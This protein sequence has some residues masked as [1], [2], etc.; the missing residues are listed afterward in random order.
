M[1]DT[2]V[3]PSAGEDDAPVGEGSEMETNV[4]QGDPQT[5]VQGESGGATVSDVGGDSSV[6]GGKRPAETSGSVPPSAKKRKS[7]RAGVTLDPS[8]VNQP[9][10]TRRGK[11]YPIPGHAQPAAPPAQ[12]VPPAPPVQTVP[13]AQPA[14]PSA[15]TASPPSTP[16]SESATRGSSRG[17]GRGRG[18]PTMVPPSRTPQTPVESERV[19][20]TVPR[21][22][23]PEKRLDNDGDP[24]PCYWD[25]SIDGQRERYN[26][27]PEKLWRRFTGLYEYMSEQ[28]EGFVYDDDVLHSG[29]Q[30]LLDE[31]ARAL[32]WLQQTIAAE[33]KTRFRDQP[34]PVYGVWAK[35]L[36]TWATWSRECVHDYLRRASLEKREVEGVDYATDAAVLKWLTEDQ[37]EAVSKQFR[38]ECEQIALR[39]LQHWKQHDYVPRENRMERDADVVPEDITRS[40]HFWRR[41]IKG[42]TRRQ[43]LDPSDS[44]NQEEMDRDSCASSVVVSDGV[45]IKKNRFLGREGP[46]HRDAWDRFHLDLSASGPSRVLQATNRRVRRFVEECPRQSR[47]KVLKILTPLLSTRPDELAQMTVRDLQ[48]KLFEYYSS[49]AAWADRHEAVKQTRAARAQQDKEDHEREA[50]AAAAAERDRV[51]QEQRE[52]S[53]SSSRGRTTGRQRGRKSQ[54]KARKTTRSGQQQQQKTRKPHRYRPGTRALMEIRRYQKSTELLLRKL[55]FSRLVREI[56]QDFRQDLCFES[57]A[58]LA[59][60]EA[61]EAYLIGLMEDTNLCAI[62]AKRITIQPKDIQLARRIRG[63]RT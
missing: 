62:H 12:T 26:W 33:L 50:S 43:A 42:A 58:M 19:P 27:L 21:E 5:R 30:G 56:T 25:E 4:G 10:R 41:L 47:W 15:Q 22:K 55:P 6:S 45:R 23:W 16:A 38:T 7:R 17:K 29:S 51:A 34:W 18:A 31:W 46:W 11:E 8:L 57:S 3:H 60:Q 2:P 61:S 32:S 39:A 28:L 63:E 35:T 14:A 9:R 36:V 37:N 49:D 59:L 53:S 54:P 48:D 52:A 1:S 44:V 24:L 20:V 13:P 40:W